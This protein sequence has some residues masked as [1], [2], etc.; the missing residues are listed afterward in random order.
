MSGSEE[1]VEMSVSFKG[2]VNGTAYDVSLTATNENGPV[3]CTAAKVNGNDVELRLINAA[4]L[5][6]M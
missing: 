3:E 2:T 5:M 6:S 1:S 4:N